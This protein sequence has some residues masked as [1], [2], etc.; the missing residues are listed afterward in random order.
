MMV[1][2]AQPRW[3]IITHSTALALGLDHGIPVVLDRMMVV[4]AQPRW[5]IIT[6]SLALL[7][8]LSVT[9]TALLLFSIA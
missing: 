9:V 5:S 7:L 4:V 1:V 2:V 6:S 8:S 3:S